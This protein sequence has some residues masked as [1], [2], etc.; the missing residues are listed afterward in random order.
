MKVYVVLRSEGDF[1]S[2]IGVFTS[3][4]KIK[5]FYKVERHR[6]RI[7]DDD[8]IYTE[9]TKFVKEGYKIEEVDVNEEAPEGGFVLWEKRDIAREVIEVMLK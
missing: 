5:K 3:K 6:Y 4:E 7:G 9:R 1:I 8:E 2:L